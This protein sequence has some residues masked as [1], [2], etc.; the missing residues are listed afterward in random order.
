MSRAYVERFAARARDAGIGHLGISEHLYRFRQAAGL[1]ETEHALARRMDDLDLYFDVLGAARDD[2]VIQAIGIEADY[3]P[4][5][6]EGT[7]ALLQRY[8]F[9]YVI[10]SVHWLGDFAVDLE[11]QAHRYEEI[12]VDRVYERYYAALAEAAASGVFHLLA[13]LDLPKIWG[14]RPSASAG[15]LH[16]EVVRIAA[17][18]GLVVEFSTAGWRRPVA[19]P[20]PAAEILRDLVAAGVKLTVSSDAHTPE[21]VGYRYPDAYAMLRSHGV[22]EVA[23]FSGRSTRMVALPE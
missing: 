8:P 12:G 23:A 17:E 10:G 5:S 15:R 20:Y 11:D 13:H 19:E 6:L 21:E 9:D 22:T 1:L 7:A 16:R 4:E 14:R 3:S 18:K 2:G